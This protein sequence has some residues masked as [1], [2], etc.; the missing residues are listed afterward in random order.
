M[1]IA[2]QHIIDGLNENPSINDLS[3]K[4]FQ[5]GHEHEIDNDIF[6]F[7]FTPNRGDCLSI[8]GIIRDLRVFYK[9]K[10]GPK[11]YEENIPALNINFENLSKDACP[12]IS[13]LK[14]KIQNKS[15]EYKNYLN[16]Y[17]KDLNI[18]KNNFFTDISN[19]VAYELGQPVHSYDY[20]LIDGEI[21]L[22]HTRKE[23]E[24]LLTLMNSE[25]ELLPNDLVFYDNTGPI[26]LAG[27]MGGMRTSC[28]KDTCEALIECAYF[29]PKYILG[30]SLKYDL[31][32]DASHKFERGVDPLCQLEVLRRFIQIV[33]DHADIKELEMHTDIS[34]NFEERFVDY[35]LELVNKILGT[36][37]KNEEFEKI[38]E[39]LDFKFDG[40]KIIVP[41]H[42]S[43][44]ARQNDIA[45]EI[46][47]AI[48]YNSIEPR[49]IEMFESKKGSTLDIEEKIKSFL[50]NNGFNEVINAPFSSCQKDHAI[51]VDNP[52]DS[53]K[54]FLRTELIPSL[55]ENIVYN[56]K[57]QKESLKF[58]EISDIYFLQN[59]KILHEK[60][61]GIIV[62]GRE[63]LNH[64]G[65]SKKLDEKYLQDLFGS[66]VT[67]IDKMI[68][69][70]NRDSIDSKIK[71]PIFAFEIPLDKLSSEIAEL[72]S[73]TIINNTFTKYREIS[74]YPSSYRDFSFSIENHEDL[75]KLYDCIEEI[76][77]EFLRDFF[78]FDYYEDKKN[79][80][81]KIGYRFIFQSN[82]KTLTEKE[83]NNSVNNLL[84]PILNIGSISVPGL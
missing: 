27:V 7:E 42:R 14:I 54:Q 60:R 12:S 33:D 39:S 26:N 84:E 71:T 50:I 82:S 20:E 11:I 49:S 68:K 81:I 51:R 73:S 74:D 75:P 17:F 52:L 23:K 55:T 53:N 22:K 80:R 59:N 10:S 40:L 67:D 1:K 25:I 31:H 32:S 16:R 38:L 36:D 58:F 83:V 79:K 30:R 24:K 37:I 4:L 15:S 76:D 61:I 77:I 34:I 9:T 5:L 8:K 57:R 46:A 62:S 47:R 45:E 43:D 66:F 48:G 21:T 6:D 2:Y 28:S 56:E 69:R 72:S 29:K 19:Y 64:I 70:V 18:N 44:I 78:I 13:F 63:A 65:F 3:E 35:D 41:S